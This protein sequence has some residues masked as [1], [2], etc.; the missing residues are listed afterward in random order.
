MHLKTGVQ[1]RFYKIRDAFVHRL[2]LKPWMWIVRPEKRAQSKK[3]SQP[4]SE[5]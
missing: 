5:S 3:G 2:S 4:K 1:R